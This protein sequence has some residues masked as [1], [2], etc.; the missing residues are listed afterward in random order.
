MEKPKHF[1][2]VVVFA[3][4]FKMIEQQANAAEMC[5]MW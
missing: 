2:A 5:K 1:A 3:S 4:L